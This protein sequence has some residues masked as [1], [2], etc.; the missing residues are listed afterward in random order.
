VFVY[1]G[2]NNCSPV[3]DGYLVDNS[4]D[5]DNPVELVN[6]VEQDN[7][8]EHDEH[9]NSVDCDDPVEHNGAHQGKYKYRISSQGNTL[10]VY[11]FQNVDL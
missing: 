11:Q 10:Y 7:S 2:R 9:V 3:E 4:V 6:P 1:I 5:L 8:A